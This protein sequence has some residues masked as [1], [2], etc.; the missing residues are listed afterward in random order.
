MMD[1]IRKVSAWFNSLSDAG[2]HVVYYAAW[3]FAG[4]LLVSILRCVK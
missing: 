3:F 4:V 2:K 1:F